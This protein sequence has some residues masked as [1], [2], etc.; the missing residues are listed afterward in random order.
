MTGLKLFGKQQLGVFW[1]MQN[2]LNGIRFTL[3][4]DIRNLLI[5]GCQ[6]GAVRLGLNQ[7]NA[8]KM[9]KCYNFRWEIL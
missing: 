7:Q 5:L 4:Q 8:K 6:A 3:E 9:G 1:S 2:A